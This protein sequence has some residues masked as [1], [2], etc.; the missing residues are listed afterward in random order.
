MKNK[1]ITIIIVWLVVAI[2]ATASVAFFFNEKKNKISAEMATEAEVA[3]I[4]KERI[5][6]ENKNINE[7]FKGDGKIDSPLRAKEEILNDLDK[8]M[9]SIIF[10]E[11]EQEGK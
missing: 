7:N 8:N 4:E 2:A 6:L 9:E 1:I 10:D 5:E 3:R 11:Q